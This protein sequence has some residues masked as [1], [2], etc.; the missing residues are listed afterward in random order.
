MAVSEPRTPHLLT[1]AG[2]TFELV[3][4][5]LGSMTGPERMR[6]FYTLHPSWR[7]QA[8]QRLGEKIEG[9]R[10]GAGELELR[11]RGRGRAQTVRR[12]AVKRSPGRSRSPS[13]TAE[14]ELLTIPAPTYFSVLA[15]VDVSERG[16][17]VNCPLP[18]HDDR[19]PSCRVYPGAGGWH[20][21]GCG[22]GGSIYD[23]AREISGI[24]D[25]GAE[26]KHLR[27]W[28]AEQLLGAAS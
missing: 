10:V 7:G 24:G 8:W 25:R 4:D 21:F 22:R 26:F 23:L 15:G 11:P 12:V 16:G 20:C 3:H 27:R 6:A 28:A 18:G 1:G 5:A 2:C 9:Q 17:M 19:T 13:A 14:D